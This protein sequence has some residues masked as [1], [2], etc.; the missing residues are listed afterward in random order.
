MM[1]FV[2]RRNKRVATVA[3]LREVDIKEVLEADM[4]AS[5]NGDMEE[6]R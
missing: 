2:F 1:Y 5:R 3:V 4:D 6:W